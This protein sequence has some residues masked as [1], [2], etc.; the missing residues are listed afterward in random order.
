MVDVA[1]TV[2]GE[3]VASL[4]GAA[5]YSAVATE[6]V[7]D[8][9]SALL[10]TQVKAHASGRPGPN[11][12]TGDYRRSWTRQKVKDGYSVGTNRPQARRLEFGFNGVDSL[13]RYYNQPPY[14]HLQPAIDIVEP[15][16]TARME[17]IVAAIARGSYGGSVVF[18]FRGIR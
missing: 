1:F 4:L 11:V 12:Q 18:G 5:E 6:Q 17:E 2:N 10:L 13:G 8:Q 14:P 7:V 16:F 15:V 3:V 9:S